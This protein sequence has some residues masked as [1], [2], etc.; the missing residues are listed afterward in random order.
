VDVVIKIWTTNF[1]VEQP[2]DCVIPA[3]GVARVYNYT[4]NIWQPKHNCLSVQIFV[5]IVVECCHM[6]AVTATRSVQQDVT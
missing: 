1:L 6:G 4:V 2:V 3:L 5:S